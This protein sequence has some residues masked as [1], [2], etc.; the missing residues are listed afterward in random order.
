[1]RALKVKLSKS[2][3][4]TV[5]RSSQWD[6]RM[7]YILVANKTYKYPSADGLESST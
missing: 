2:S 6:K 7:V 5:Q 1:M 4:L 3:L